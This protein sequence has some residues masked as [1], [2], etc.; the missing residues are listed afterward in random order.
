MH[1]TDIAEDTENLFVEIMAFSNLGKTG[2]EAVEELLKKRT[3]SESS[4]ASES[5]TESSPTNFSS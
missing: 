1:I 4:I 3:S 2:A 5:V